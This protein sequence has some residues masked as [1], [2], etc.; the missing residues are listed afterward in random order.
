MNRHKLIFQAVA[1]LIYL[2][3]TSA[4]AVQAQKLTFDRMAKYERSY[5]DKSYTT[6]AYA[7]STNDKC[8][9]EI[10]RHR[11]EETKAFLFDYRFGKRYDYIVDSKVVDGK[12]LHEFRYIKSIN[13]ST[14]PR[15]G[16]YYDFESVSTE[17]D[18]E[19]VK[20]KFY[21][22]KAQTKILSTLILQNQKSDVNYFPLFRFICL[23]L[24][25]ADINFNY[26]NGGLILSC[27]LDG[28][29]SKAI[30]KEFEPAE[31]EIEVPQNAVVLKS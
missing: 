2:L 20:L 28:G 22:N 10:N 1:V 21:K 3:L 12:V 5:G 7:I 29:D 18:I 14:S 24:F 16:E 30:L 19:T 6:S 13:L 11:Q 23:H 26:K 25:E 8:F 31:L 15:K 27:V 9:L 4:N 17:G